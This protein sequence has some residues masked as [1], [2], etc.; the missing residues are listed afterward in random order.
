MQYSSSSLIEY[1]IKLYYFFMTSV[2]G[3]KTKHAKNHW[4]KNQQFNIVRHKLQD[5]SYLKLKI[6][7]FFFSSLLN[8]IWDKKFQNGDHIEKDCLYLN[9]LKSTKINV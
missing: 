3:T 6:W 7:Q 2:V 8:L 1:L 5:S 4:Q 9:S